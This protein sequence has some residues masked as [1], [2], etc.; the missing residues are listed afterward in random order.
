MAENLAYLPAVSPPTFGS[1]NSPYYYV[2]D[3][4]GTNVDEA[5]TTANYS[6]Y[7]VLYN[8]TAAK[9]ACPPGWHLPSDA[10][11][12]QL[13]MALGMTTAQAD[14]ENWRGTDQGIQMKATKGWNN[15]GSGT[16]TSGF[17]ALPSGVYNGI[18]KNF[19]GIDNFGLWWSSTESNSNNSWGRFISD[20][21]S[22]VCRIQSARSEGFSVRCVKD[23][24]APVTDFTAS[25]TSIPKGRTIQFTDKST[26][27]PTSWSW[28]FGDGTT[29]NEQN[30]SKTYSTIGTF[31]VTLV[32]TNLFGNNSKTLTNYITITETTNTFT[33]QRDGKSYKTVQIGNQI[34]MSENLAYLPSVSPPSDSSSSAPYYYVYGYSGTDVAAAKATTNYSRYG[35]LYNWEAA[36]AACP[37]GWHLPSETE[38][39]QL[40][41][42]LGM[43]QVEAD[44][45]GVY[46]GTDQGSQMKDISGWYRNNGT[47]SSGFAALPSGYYSNDMTFQG[48]ELIDNWWSSTESST[49]NALYLGV[50]YENQYV[51]KDYGAKLLGFSVRCIKD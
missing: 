8:W 12:K 13:E 5:K 14:A 9:A 11:W 42:T 46:C 26:N 41:M 44:Q 47:N 10:E 36:K 17:S 40:V 6:K 1:T 23:Y 25:A 3:Y 45:I 30:P 16:N 29:S 50:H 4:A 2:Y 21:W 34:W 28:D 27:S 31:S 19:S 48:I 37:P 33:D 22:N 20:I 18:L 43:T 24:D 39:K 7:G 51:Y 15:T 35:V 38:W 49:D 32:A